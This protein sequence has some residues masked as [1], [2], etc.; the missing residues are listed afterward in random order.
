M[1]DNKTY[2]VT[3]GSGFIGIRMCNAI[4]A[5]GA[6]LKLILRKKNKGIE[7]KQYV[8]DLDSGVI[9]EEAFIGVNTI[10]HLAGYAHD[11]DNKINLNQ[12]Q[13]INVE[14]TINIANLAVKHK[15]ENFIFISSVKAGGN[16]VFS[17]C[18]TELDQNN[19]RGDYGRT[20]REAELE[21]LRIGKENNIRISILRPSLV[22]GPEVKGNLQ[23]MI[24]AVRK[25]WFPPLPETGNKKSMIHVDDLVNA[26]LMVSSCENANGEIYIVTD[27][28]VY[29]SREIYEVVCN[30][31]EKSLPKWHIP[32][33]LFK[34]ASKISPKIKVKV[35]KLFR[36]EYYCS[37]KIESIGFMP[38]RTLKD[39]NETVF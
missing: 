25:G 22:Y 13:K 3:G 11:L 21:L 20:K 32:L 9:D 15:V 1:A 33:F 36:D 6:N 24:S 38:N 39:M 37:K 5:S 8:S 35:D 18:M 2:L 19:P 12:Y 30:I 14:L 16:N 26:I 31:S 23:L 4:N 10:I 28:K 34:L 29:S 17:R 7:Y 27:G